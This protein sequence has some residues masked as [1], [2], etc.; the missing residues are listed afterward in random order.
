MAG[1]V[2]RDQFPSVWKVLVENFKEWIPDDAERKAFAEK[3]I[4]EFKSEKHRGYLKVYQSRCH[5]C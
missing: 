1:R 4:D 2:T 3:A 5:C